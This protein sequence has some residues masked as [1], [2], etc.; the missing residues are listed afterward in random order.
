LGLFLGTFFQCIK[1]F[2][3][4]ISKSFFESPIFNY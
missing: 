4:Q 2:F 3:F 1:K